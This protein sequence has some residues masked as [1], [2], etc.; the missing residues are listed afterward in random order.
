MSLQVNEFGLTELWCPPDPL[1]DV[2]FV[3]GLN[4]HP[5][6]TWAAENVKYGRQEG[7]RSQK[8]D[9]YWP[10]DLLPKDLDQEHCRILTYGYD[11]N[12]SAFRDGASKDHIHHHAE[13]LT[14]RLAANRSRVRALERPLIFVVHSLGGLVVKRMLI[15]SNESTHVNQERLRSI[16]IST[17]GI[18]FLGTPHNGSDLAK[19]GS[20]LQSIC[21]AA[22]PKK[23]F[24]SQ[25]QLV[26][27]LETNN[28]TLQ[29]INR[30][31]TAISSKFRIY[32]FHEAKPMD[33]KGTRQFVVDEDSAA[34]NL[35]GVERAGIEKDHSHMCK[36]ENE[37]SP[38]Y[39]LVSEGIQRYAGEA[40]TT[41][42]V[43]WQAAR[44]NQHLQKQD[45]VRE[46]LGGKITVDSI[47]QKGLTFSDDIP[48]LN[49]AIKGDSAPTSKNTSMGAQIS[50][51]PMIERTAHPY[52]VEEF[53]EIP[54]PT[55]R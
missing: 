13:T 26:K 36:F 47:V 15:H 55:R 46:L 23:L 25:S 9:V 14:A 30:D 28:E 12:V 45:E 2:V 43:R 27:A 1:V 52:E 35:Q 49:P 53:E 40:P 38:G 6:N 44:R 7:I 37:N 16:F 11:A 18:L 21:A 50:P 24:D 42:S 19:W 29:L 54:I 41:I 3:H 10:R 17:Y 5:Y 4:G 51:R 39:D 22:L 31:F 48:D 33:L 20:M 32:F 34:P 8:S